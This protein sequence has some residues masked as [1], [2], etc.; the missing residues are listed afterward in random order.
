MYSLKGWS[1]YHVAHPDVITR[2]GATPGMTEAELIDF[3]AQNRKRANTF[4]ER[5]PDGTVIIRSSKTLKKERRDKMCPKQRIVQEGPGPAIRT[6]DHPELS[7]H[8]CSH[9]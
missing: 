5:L 2:F 7:C 8:A 6:A 3:V 4:E 9:P 1:D